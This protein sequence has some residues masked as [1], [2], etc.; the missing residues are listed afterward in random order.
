MARFSDSP[1]VEVSVEVAATPEELWPL[2]TDINLP[3]RFQDEFRGGEWIDDG[4][5]L[6]ARFVGS[7]RRQ[8]HDW[9]TTSWVVVHDPFREFGWAVSDPDDPGATWTYRLE[10]SPA[11]TVL[12]YRRKLGPGPS[13][14]TSAIERHP[15][16]EEEIIARRDAEHR[17]HMQAVV[18]G[19]KALAEQ[20]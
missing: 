2:V 11:G 20:Q 8:G 16:R 5:A 19:I 15:D 14:V 13:G 10:P 12:T 1:I 3:A 17:A 18:D 7:N 4:P 6:G 9:E